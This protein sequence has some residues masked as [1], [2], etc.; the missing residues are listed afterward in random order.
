MIDGDSITDEDHGED[1]AADPALEEDPADVALSS[2]WCVED[3]HT[4]FAGGEEEERVEHQF[5]DQLLFLVMGLDDSLFG[6]HEFYQ[7]FGFHVNQTFVHI[8]TDAHAN[9]LDSKVP[10]D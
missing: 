8:S 6:L 1:A 5:D 10:G 7:L 2:A 3:K 4:D 9:K